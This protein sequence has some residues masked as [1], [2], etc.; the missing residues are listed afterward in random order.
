MGDL[1]RMK[2]EEPLPQ[3]AEGLAR[4]GLDRVLLANVTFAREDTLI[5]ASTFIGQRS[6]TG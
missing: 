5:Q 6:E 2:V 1:R 4:R 3:L